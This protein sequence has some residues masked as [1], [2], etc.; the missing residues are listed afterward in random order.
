MQKQNK[1]SS[2]NVMN[3]LDSFNIQEASDVQ[4]TIIRGETGHREMHM[5]RDRRV[6]DKSFFSE[7]VKSYTYN[8]EKN[9]IKIEI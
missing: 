3:L 4:I 8:F 2:V 6:M 9:S 1:K 7:L 5:Y